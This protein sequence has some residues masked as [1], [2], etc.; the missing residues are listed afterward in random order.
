MTKSIATA[1]INRETAVA[2]IDAALAATVPSASRLP[3]PSSTPPVT[4]ARSSAPT[5][6][7]SL[8]SMLPSTRSEFRLV[9]VP[10]PCLERLCDQRSKVAPL[11]YRPRM[12][13]VGGGYPILEDGKLIGG[14]GISGG[15]YQ[16]DQDA[17]VEALMKIGFQLPA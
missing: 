12:V 6:R 11:A 8:P 15:N 3:S 7:R 5:M 16:Q 13:A 1:S 9:W 17:C 4:C 14:I 10:D 2:L